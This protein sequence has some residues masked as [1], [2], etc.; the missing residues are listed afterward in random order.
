MAS[1]SPV[2]TAS[3][4]TGFLGMVL[5]GSFGPNVKLK[6]PNAKTIYR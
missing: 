3:E 5:T 2:V 1:S 4:I 6:A